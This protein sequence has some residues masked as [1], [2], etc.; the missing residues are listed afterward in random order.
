MGVIQEEEYSKY[1]DLYKFETN[2]IDFVRAMKYI[3][4]GDARYAS[5]ARLVAEDMQS[6]LADIIARE[7]TQK[8]P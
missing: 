7:L 8:E 5:D 3:R 4:D 1:P 6:F 2:C